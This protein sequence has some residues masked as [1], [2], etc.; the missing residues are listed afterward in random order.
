MLF[1]SV[2]NTDCICFYTPV[3]RNGD[4]SVRSMPS[5]P[6]GSPLPLLL[7]CKVYFSYTNPNL[8]I[9]LYKIVVFDSSSKATLL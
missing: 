7:I 4:G 8:W 5:L 9:M 3:A 1:R 2:D 6:L